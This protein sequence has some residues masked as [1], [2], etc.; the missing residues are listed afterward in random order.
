MV[1]EKLKR[2]EWFKVCLK[3]NY[4]LTNKLIEKNL[5]EQMSKVE[6]VYLYLNE[7]TRISLP[8]LLNN[9]LKNLLKKIK[10]N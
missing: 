3:N 8:L 2:K 10:N 6:G 5:I 9:D 4:N 7:L 1:D